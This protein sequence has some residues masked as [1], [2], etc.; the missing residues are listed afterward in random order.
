L[1]LLA[2]L[3]E[4]FAYRKLNYF[5]KVKDNKLYILESN[6]LTNKVI[7]DVFVLFWM[8]IVLPVKEALFASENETQEFPFIFI[9][10]NSICGCTLSS[11]N[12][13]SSLKHTCSD[14]K[15]DSPYS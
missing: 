5:L 15:I 11:G 13:W 2:S 6:R 8:S 14:N 12:Q 7:G 1:P 4:R 3:K 9:L 10:Y